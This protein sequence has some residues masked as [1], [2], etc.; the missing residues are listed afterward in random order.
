MSGF[1]NAK[2][3]WRFQ[4]LTVPLF[5]PLPDVPHFGVDSNIHILHLAAS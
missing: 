4:G 3:S 2:S 1:V 5:L